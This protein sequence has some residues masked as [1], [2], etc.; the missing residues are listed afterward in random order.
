MGDPL[1]YAKGNAE[2]LKKYWTE[3][4]GAAKI[5]WGE[6][7][8]FDRCVAEVTKDAHGEVPDVKGYCANL[9]KR[10]LGVW[11]GQEDKHASVS[12]AAG[13]LTLPALVTMPAVEIVAAGTWGLSSGENT[14]TRDD[15]AAA[16]EASQ[17]PAV[18]SPLIKL[19][20]VDPRFDGEPA[21]GRVTNLALSSQ[22]NKITGDLA[23]M[24]GWLGAVC[25]SAF[26]SRSIEGCY[27]FRCQVG[28]THP[29]VITGL[30]L[31]GVTP[32]GVGVLSTLGDVAALYGVQAAARTGDTWTL[33]GAA[34]AQPVQAASV[35]IEDVRRAYYAQ[36]STSLT[37]W[38]TEM[39][40]DPP[41]LI[42]CDDATDSVYRVPVT[43]ASDG[44]VS[45][46][47]P[48]QVK[49]EYQDVAASRKTGQVAV[50]A[51][52][53]ESR[54][55]VVEAA[56]WD[57]Q[58]NVGA[59]GDDP[60]KS[61]LGAM[62]AIP[63]DTKSDSKLPHH[64][65]SDGKVGAANPAGCSAAIGAINGA[66]GGMT[67]VSAAEQRAAYNHLAAHLKDAGQTPPEYNGPS[68]SAG[69]QAG[70]QVDAA[71]GHGNYDG[72]H[73]HAHP[74]FG[75]QGGDATH[76]HEHSHSGD[77]VHDHH[78]AA[79]APAA[80][81]NDTKGASKV[82]LT[83]EHISSLRAS[84]GLGDNDD[85][86]PELLVSSATKLKDRADAKVSAS[87]RAL[88]DGVIAV[89]REAWDGLNKRVSDAEAYQ[90]RQA[91]KE[92]DTVIA[93]AVREGKFTVA[94]SDH[95]KRLWDVDPEGT[96][97]VLAGLQ[98]NVVPIN[99]IGAVGSNDPDD[100]DDEYAAVFG[101]PTA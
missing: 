61:Q 58:S 83:N 45:F 76:M 86:T 97:Q 98:K 10:A 66:H 59:L 44:G 9:H 51:S 48:V 80:A 55:G 2:T 19:G 36:A 96:R 12:A 94:R 26:P 39:Q 5:R 22:G 62:F 21:V 95:W 89:E 15:L 49:V 52:L 50:F 37:N 100:V 79:Q 67:G 75:A 73:S 18:G 60:S 42:V 74:A 8:D 27:D 33:E 17:C 65:A 91:V 63:G 7:H 32:P 35:T 29:F 84:L 13:G 28:H 56:S 30:A 78:T 93:S 14:F 23:G 47:S 92:R 25:A 64:D 4:E 16:V 72:S 68:A 82:D 70:I 46:G 54:A 24:P 40:L 6:P 20:H 81:G 85:L 77:A 38:I 43:I 3:G 53:E 34:M 11:P 69:D 1:L 57:A 71:G 101:R 90:K 87:S 88:P 41:Q 31:L 99:D